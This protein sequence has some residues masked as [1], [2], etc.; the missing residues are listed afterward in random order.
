[1]AAT[2]EYREEMDIVSNFLA[3]CCIMTKDAKVSAKDLYTAYRTWCDGNG[4]PA[5]SQRVLGARLREHD[6]IP[7]RSTGGLH[8]WSGVALT[9]YQE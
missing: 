5:S 7:F 1:M 2:A 9:C 4:E 8:C 3:D 6:L